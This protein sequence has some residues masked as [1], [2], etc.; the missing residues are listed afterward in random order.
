[1]TQASPEKSFVTTV[2]ID[3]AE[4]EVRF[5]AHAAC[6]ANVGDSN[7]APR[8]PLWSFTSVNLRGVTNIC[9]ETGEI[10]VSFDHPTRGE[11]IRLKLK[12]G[13]ALALA[14]SILA[15]IAAFPTRSQSPTSSGIPSV[16]GSIPVDGQ[17]V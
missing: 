7:D 14:E 1:M 2:G 17:K 10:G 9:K 15:Y 12:H 16:D 3:V 11:T 5:E 6:Q 8:R 13:A 4:N